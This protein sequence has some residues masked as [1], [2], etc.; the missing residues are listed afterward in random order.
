MH[1]MGTIVVPPL[2]YLETSAVAD[3]LEEPRFKALRERIERLSSAG[4][5]L[6]CTSLSTLEELVT[7]MPTEPELVAAVKWL[8]GV[9]PSRLIRLQNEDVVR[10]WV[11]HATAPDADRQSC[12]AQW[13]PRLDNPARR[14]SA[15]KVW[16]DDLRATHVRFLDRYK[17]LFSSP[18]VP[19]F[20]G[21]KPQYWTDPANLFRE[22]RLLVDGLF[23][24]PAKFVE[25][26]QKL[27][28][29]GTPG[30]TEDRV[31]EC[32]ENP[33]VLLW[34]GHLFTGV[35]KQVLRRTSDD[36]LRNDA[37][38]GRHI[39][40]A[41][42]SDALVTNDRRLAEAVTHL[43]PGEVPRVFMLKDWGAELDRCA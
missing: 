23:D 28:P 27:V 10:R 25:L 8:R 18:E 35:A 30:F 7:T 26:V 13:N 36:D 39:M 20:L 1:A 4:R 17:Q 34:L 15:L 42:V 24:S 9:T 16:R 19:A 43:R 40:F 2:F 12:F 3:L 31:W 22:V 21:R 33:W 6:L 11:L 5:L 38:D 41:S 29:I 32:R 14:R 37:Y